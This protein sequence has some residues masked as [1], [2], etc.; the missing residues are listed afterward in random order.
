MILD[1]ETYIPSLMDGWSK[2]SELRVRLFDQTGR[3]DGLTFRQAAGII[4]KATGNSVLVNP[5]DKET[6]SSLGGEDGGYSRGSEGRYPETYSHKGGGLTYMTGSWRGLSIKPSDEANRWLL[7]CTQWWKES[8]SFRAQVIEAA[9]AV[10][11]DPQFED[12]S[13]PE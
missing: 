5:Y 1:D 9:E 12:I 10:L 2:D 13:L 3:L 4:E 6:I 7:D 8:E 11:N